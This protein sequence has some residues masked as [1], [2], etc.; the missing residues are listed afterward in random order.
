[1]YA[2]LRDP[3]KLSWSESMLPA[4]GGAGSRREARGAASGAAPRPGKGGAVELAPA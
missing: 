2:S 4:R 1:M 3:S